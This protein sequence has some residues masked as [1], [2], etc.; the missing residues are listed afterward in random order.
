M[1]TSDNITTECPHC[2]EPGQDT[3]RFQWINREL[4]IIISGAILLSVGAVA[5]YILLNSFVGVLLFFSVVILSGNMTMRKGVKGVIKNRNLDMN[6][7]MTVASLGAFVIG[8][9]AEGALVMYLF[10]IAEY[11]ETYASAK[12]KN[13]VS[14]L[15]ELTPETT[16]RIVD[17]QEEVVHTH[18]LRIDDRIAVRPGDMIPI[19]GQIV[20]GKSSL[21][22]ASITGESMPVVK[23]EQ[24]TVYAGTINLDGYLEIR[25]TSHPD[26]TLLAKIAGIVEDAQKRKSKTHSFIQRFAH[27]YTPVVIMLAFAVMTIPPLLLQQSFVPWVYRGFV[28]LVTSCPCALIL[29]TPV[30]IISGL[31]AASKNGVLI[32]GGSFIE[33]IK[34]MKMIVFDKTG[35]LTTGTP[36]VIQVS[37]LAN[38]SENEI[39]KLAVSLESLS[40]HP[41]AAAVQEFAHEKDVTP[42]LVEGFISYPGQGLTGIIAGHQYWIG[43]LTFLNT[44]NIPN[45]DLGDLSS[46]ISGKTLMYLA[47][48]KGILG[49]IA[50]RDTI[51]HD[52]QSIINQIHSRGIK[53]MMMTG[54]NPEIAQIIADQLGI[55]TYAS[56][57]LPNEK[58]EL[59]T[60]LKTQYGSVAMV[61]DGIN[62]APALASADIGIAMAARGTDIAIEAADIALMSDE[63]DK[64]SFLL[65]LSNKTM[66]VVKQ[67]IGLVLIVKI[68]LALLGLVG[69]ANLWMAAGIGDMGISLAVILNSLRIGQTNQNKIKTPIK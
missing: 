52:A 45:T 15:L 32:K 40:N 18:A 11:L 69:L 29:S 36:Q 12:S 61:G 34:D 1:I 10:Y 42:L 62:D 43:N 49:V 3:P 31:T 56:N 35:T 66:T 47:D 5:Q 44:E 39:I 68:S 23:Q 59:L 6:F 67:N 7:L 55:T 8:E 63:L 9:G 38:R 26:D 37:P 41:L 53:T 27:Y 28:L 58:N 4:G 64:I 13:A 2:P 65:S 48:K 30:A 25:V 14:S 22:Q 24:D 19:D 17:G 20:V 54:D 51:R 57:L 46:L 16:Y 33:D 21:D 50:F 60:E